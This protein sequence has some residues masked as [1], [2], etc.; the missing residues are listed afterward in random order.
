MDVD[1]IVMVIVVIIVVVVVIRSL[2]SLVVSR[3]CS[4]IVV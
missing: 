2:V 4:V 3:R 1:V